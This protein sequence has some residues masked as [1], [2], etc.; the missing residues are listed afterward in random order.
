[1]RDAQGN[2]LAIYSKKQEEGLKWDEQH[3]YGSSRLGMWR[4]DTLVPA[5]APV[6]GEATSIYDSL[7]LGS[8]SYE[9]S[10]HLGNVLSTIS[11]KKIGNDSSGVVNYY[12]AEVLSQNDYYPGGMLLPGRTYQAGSD[13]YRYGFQSQEKSTEI[14]ES[15]YTAE[16]WQ[17]DARIVRRWNVD[18]VFKE[19]ESPYA[20]FGN[21]PIW[22]TDLNGADTTIN[23]EVHENSTNG[24]TLSGVTVS[25]KKPKEGSTKVFKDA[26]AHFSGGTGGGGVSFSDEKRY[27]HRGSKIYGAQGGWYSFDRYKEI[28][29]SRGMAIDFGTL[30]PQAVKPYPPLPSSNAEYNLQTFFDEVGVP[31]D[32]FYD[33]LGAAAS[34]ASVH[35]AMSRSGL[36][37][38]SPFNVESFIGLGQLAKGLLGP[39]VSKG[40]GYVGLGYSKL[41]YRM[42]GERFFKIHPRI[43]TVGYADIKGLG[44]GQYDAAHR[45]SSFLRNDILKSG[46][47]GV[48]NW[49]T[50]HYNLDLG[51]QQ[52]SIGVNPWKRTIFHEGPGLFK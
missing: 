31:N 11:D 19:H 39:M 28:L 32:G 24:G 16:F 48:K 34:E 45:A 17:Y 52:F 41:G 40:V 49:R 30:F 42:F 21:N 46:K 26:V 38:L 5:A 1:V 9:L 37:E 27:Y 23:G 25:A 3:L 2:V 7:L 6:V 14:N 8:M 12:L 20:A 50:I 36:I 44:F 10:N 29:K 47:T 18:P 13:S 15:S 33:A 22:F 4:Y 51:G 35:Q 43:S